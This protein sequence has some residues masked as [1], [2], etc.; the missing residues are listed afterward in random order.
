VEAEVAEIE[1]LQRL[2]NGPVNGGTNNQPFGIIRFTAVLSGEREPGWIQ[3]AQAKIC[4][5]TKN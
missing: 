2:S 1:I 5:Q 3:I 4:G